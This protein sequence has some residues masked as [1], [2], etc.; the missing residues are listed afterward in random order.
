MRP[1][2]KGSGCLVT[3]ETWDDG[4]KKKLYVYKRSNLDLFLR[5]ME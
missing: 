2:D 4:R 3:I 1:K 5:K